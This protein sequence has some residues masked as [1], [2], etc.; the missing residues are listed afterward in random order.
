MEIN[1]K[2]IGLFDATLLVSGSMIGSG[3]FIV[4]ADMSRLLG[5]A[6]LVIFAWLLTGIITLMAALSFGELASMMPNSGG[7]YNFIT[8]IYGKVTGFV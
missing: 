3:I 6:Y 1:S 4:T 8:R 5:N 7:Q 2:K